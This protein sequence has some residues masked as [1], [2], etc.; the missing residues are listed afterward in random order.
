MSGSCHAGSNMLDSILHSGLRSDAVMAGSS[1]LMTETK[2][3]TD[4]PKSPFIMSCIILL[5]SISQN[6]Y[7][8]DLF[9]C[10]AFVACVCVC[11]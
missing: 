11:V 9:I 7:Y 2:A 1:C 8:L 6:S 4:T 5:C 3:A 10:V